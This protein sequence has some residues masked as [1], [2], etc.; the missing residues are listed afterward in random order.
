MKPL[1]AK[2][3][4]DVPLDK[5]FDYLA[6]EGE[7][8]QVGQRVSVPFGPRKMVGVI[9]A[10]GKHSDVLPARLKAIAHVFHETPLLSPEIFRLLHFCSDYYHHPLGEVIFNALPTAVRQTKPLTLPKAEYFRLSEAGRQADPAGLPARA[11][12]KRRL[13]LALRE[14]GSLRREDLIALSPSA[15]TA[16]KSFIGQGWVEE[17]DGSTSTSPL[18]PAKGEPEL[19]PAQHQAVEALCAAL[20]AFRP[21]LLHGVTGS[22]KTEV[23]LRTVVAALQ[24]GA[25]VLVLVPEINLTPQLEQ[26]FRARF[27][28]T[29]LVS[30]HSNLS[31]GER[32][33]N[34]LAA[35]SGQAQIVLGT[36]L[37]VFAPL[38]RLGLIIVDEEHDASFK[39]QEGLRYSAR[40]VAMIRAKQVG[41]PIVLGSAT[42]AL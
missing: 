27:P 24:Q 16:L 1:I 3:A 10:L 42:P 32:L 4:L 33:K 29:R 18:A 7:L 28:A 34:Y 35:Q 41:I 11:V 12:V 37:A 8:L 15:G 38:P 25:Q 40:D 19:N 9:V 26:R 30:L 31:D 23:Y 2:V 39:Q 20:G 17:C 36:R 14:A 21:F 5:L 13:L 6:P 22:G